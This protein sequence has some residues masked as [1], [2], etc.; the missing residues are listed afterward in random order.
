MG[1]LQTPFNRIRWSRGRALRDRQGAPN[2]VAQGDS[3]SSWREHSALALH[4]I[5][6]VGVLFLGLARGKRVIGLGTHSR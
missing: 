4:A 3:A 1:E 2:G 6:T 5:T